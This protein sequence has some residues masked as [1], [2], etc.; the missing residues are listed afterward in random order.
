MKYALFD[1]A[2][3]RGIGLGEV[4]DNQSKYQKETD[5]IGLIEVESLPE[6]DFK[7]VNGKVVDQSDDDFLDEKIK[8]A[9]SYLRSK[10]TGLLMQC[11]WTQVS[12]APVDQ[13]AWASYRQAL[14]DMPQNTT[15]PS[16]PVWPNPPSD[17]GS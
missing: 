5:E 11:D 4:P 8:E 15:D 6:N 1:K 17:G 12:D 16:N 3:G 14:R 13:A 7:V 9:W 2:T 10:R